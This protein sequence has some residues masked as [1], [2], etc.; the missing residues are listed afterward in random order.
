MM[1]R[2]PSS[3]IVRKNISKYVIRSPFPVVKKPFAIVIS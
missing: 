3:G 2:P 1:A